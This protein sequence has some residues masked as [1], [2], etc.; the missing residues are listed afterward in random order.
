[1]GIADSSQQ[2]LQLRLLL[3]ILPVADI[4]FSTSN[5]NK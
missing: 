2:F 4:T 5:E 3:H 1:M